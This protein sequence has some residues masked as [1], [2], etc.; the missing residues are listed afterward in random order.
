MVLCPRNILTLLK[1]PLGKSSC[2]LLD[3]GRMLTLR[4]RM[5]LTPL[6]A[7]IATA[8]NAVKKERQQNETGPTPTRT[9]ENLYGPRAMKT[10]RKRSTIGS[11]NRQER[12]SK[13]ERDRCGRPW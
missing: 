5:R 6:N 10:K 4:C 9:N 8:T 12:L 2:N 7:S 11:R 13:P 3:A 1:K